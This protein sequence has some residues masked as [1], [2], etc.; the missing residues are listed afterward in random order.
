VEE[1][2][3]PAKFTNLEEKIEE[4][5]QAIR[6]L[7]QTN[8]ELESKIYYLEEAL[9]AKASAEHRHVEEKLVIG[10]KIEGLIT[11]VDKALSSK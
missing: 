8:S 3:F 7:Q 4:L 9:K 10:K 1:E 6:S 5:V 11:A 2:R